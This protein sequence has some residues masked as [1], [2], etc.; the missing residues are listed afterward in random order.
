MQKSLA[1][2]ELCAVLHGLLEN[3]CALF[4][5]LLL[6]RAGARDE[7]RSDS[8]RVNGLGHYRVKDE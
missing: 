6:F 2:S 4:T 3:K 8:S 1:H 5:R 7:R